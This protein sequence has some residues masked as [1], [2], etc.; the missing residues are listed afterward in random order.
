[1]SAITRLWEMQ[2]YRPKNVYKMWLGRFYLFNSD[3]KTFIS[4]INYLFG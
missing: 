4:S 1:M 2:P 3:L